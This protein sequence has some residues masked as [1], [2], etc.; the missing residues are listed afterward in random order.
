MSTW[1]R[2]LSFLLSLTL[3]TT[4]VTEVPAE[5]EAAVTASGLGE[6]QP[7][8]EDSTAAEEFPL[9]SADEAGAAELHPFNTADFDYFEF[10]AENGIEYADLEE[11]VLTLSRYGRNSEEHSKRAEELE[12][13]PGQLIIKFQKDQL[14]LETPAG[15]QAAEEW[16]TQKSAE[17]K[18]VLLQQMALAG[19]RPPADFAGEVMQIKNYSYRRNNLEVELL[20]SDRSAIIIPELNKDPKV[21]SAYVSTI[22][23]LDLGTKW[24]DFD[25]Q[26]ED[27][28]FFLDSKNGGSQSVWPFSLSPAELSATSAGAEIIVAVLDTGIDYTHSDLAPYLWD[29]SASCQDESGNEITG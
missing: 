15:R 5:A 10:L 3:L 16:F 22:I 18:P 19:Q 23:Q 28:S 13:F 27:A 6:E 2:L 12:Y 25:N 9:V 4:L 14:D 17:L 11:E 26:S 21:K 20:L 8:T 1:K 24:A 29:G 7:V